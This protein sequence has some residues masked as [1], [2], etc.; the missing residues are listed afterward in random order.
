[1]VRFPLGLGPITYFPRDMNSYYFRFNETQRVF[2]EVGSNFNSY[3]AVLKLGP[4]QSSFGAYEI[5]GM[6]RGNI[7]VIDQDVPPGDY[8]LTVQVYKNG[9]TACGM[10]NFRGILNMH[11]AMAEHLPGSNHLVKA[12]TMCELRNS[13]QA[14]SQIFAQESK[15]RKGNEEVI[16]PIGIYY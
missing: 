16:D 4:T 8:R 3:H 6:Q 7:N 10:F 13:E 11:S 2:F 15:T 14:P 1:M 12:A 5:L 9:D